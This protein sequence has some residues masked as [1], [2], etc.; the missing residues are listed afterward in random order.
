MGK[1]EKLFWMNDTAIKDSDKT[2]FFHLLDEGEG[3]GGV[4]FVVWLK[5]FKRKQNMKI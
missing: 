3:G 2:I 5:I 1:D 4:D